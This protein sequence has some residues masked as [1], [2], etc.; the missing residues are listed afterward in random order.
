MLERAINP[1]S[2]K[3][4]LEAIHNLFISEALF[5]YS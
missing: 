5:P 3:F 1:L 4:V 2:V